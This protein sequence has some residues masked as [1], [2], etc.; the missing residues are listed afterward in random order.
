MLTYLGVIE[1]WLCYSQNYIVCIGYVTVYLSGYQNNHKYI[2]ILWNDQLS[3]ALPDI[4]IH[5]VTRNIKKI[6]SWLCSLC[7]FW[8]RLLSPGV[9]PWRLSHEIPWSTPNPPLENLLAKNPG[10]IPGGYKRIR[11]LPQM[12]F[13]SG[14]GC[15]LYFIISVS[16]WSIW[17]NM[18]TMCIIFMMYRKCFTHLRH[19]FIIGFKWM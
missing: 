19:R 7:I 5:L 14:S 17:Y 18:W 4:C 9:S 3:F 13:K 6:G 11:F 2:C 16:F 12:K 10:W 15:V 8:W 1:F